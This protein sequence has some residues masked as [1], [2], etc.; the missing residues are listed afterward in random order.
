M[1]I[2]L[3]VPHCTRK[4]RECTD[5]FYFS[6]LLRRGG[7][8]FQKCLY[9]VRSGVLNIYS[10]HSGGFLVHKHKTR[11]FDVLGE[12]PDI[13]RVYPNQ[14]KSL[15]IV[16]EF[17]GLKRQLLFS[18]VSQMKWREPFDFPSGIDVF[19]MQMVSTP[20]DLKWSWGSAKVG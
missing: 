7:I 3:S 18:E 9:C 2:D 11:K 17:H 15:K 8:F 13:Y 19:F 20:G 5:Y 6:E 14:L 16:E 10:Y 4:Q 12:R 1:Y